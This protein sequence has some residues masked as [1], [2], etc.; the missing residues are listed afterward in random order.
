LRLGRMFHEM[1]K[2]RWAYAFIAP[3]FILYLVFGF[4]PQIFSVYL[5]FSK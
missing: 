2:S 3:F 1:R 5:S 4:L